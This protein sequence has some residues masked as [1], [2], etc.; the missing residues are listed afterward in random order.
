M[1]YKKSFYCDITAFHPGVTGSC[2]SNEIR[3]PNGERQNFLL[4]LG[5]FQETQY[6]SLNQK[7]DFNP[8]LF[9]YVFA[10]HAHTDHIGRIPM[11][12]KNGFKGTV[13][14]TVITQRILELFLED[15]L[16]INKLKHAAPIFS[17]KN[18]R[19][20]MAHTKAVDYNQPIR[21]DNY[22]TACFY[23]NAHI[24]GAASIGFDIHYPGHEEISL[25]YSSD[26]KLHSDYLKVP[27][28]PQKV[29]HKKAIIMMEATYGTTYTKN[30][31]D[32]F[33]RDL[34][35]V[36]EENKTVFLSSFAQARPLDLMYTIRKLQDSGKIAPNIMVYID[37][38]LL[39]SCLNVYLNS[40]EFFSKSFDEILPYNLMK[41][42]PKRREAIIRSHHAKIIIGT[43]GTCDNGPAQVYIPLLIDREDAAIFINSG[44]LPPESIGHTLLETPIGESLSFNGTRLIKRAHVFQNKAS[45]SHAKLNDIIEFLSR[46]QR[47]QAIIFN[48]GDPQSKEYAAKTIRAN[49]NIHAKYVGIANRNSVI[50]ICPWGYVKE[51]EKPKSLAFQ[52]A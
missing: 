8:A 4:D 38:T 9:D 15:T 51:F 36:L 11:A 12:F 26:L 19:Q 27:P 35:E 49:T 6:L 18:I 40:Y 1:A 29:Y 33:E 14:G 2:F 45:S 31:P 22:L 20:T 13:F 5:L 24:P 25:F 7:L 34:V 46:F 16:M 10:T 52:T 30:I 41:V 43:S 23:G 48:H 28:I 47:P 50:R 32:T 21:L 39:L 17:E 44:Y 37:G 3:Y 42:N